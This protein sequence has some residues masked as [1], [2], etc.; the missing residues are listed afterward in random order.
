MMMLWSSS[1][2]MLQATI[3]SASKGTREFINILKLTKSHGIEKIGLILKELDKSNRYS[4]EEVL[5]LLR[6]R[7]DKTRKKVIPQE[8]IE[9]MGIANIKSSSPE[10]TQYNSLIKGGENI[11]RK[12]I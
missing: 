11:E 12:V 9:S 8:I 4:Y 1:N 6:F 5:S 7:E 2:G 3:K 10:I